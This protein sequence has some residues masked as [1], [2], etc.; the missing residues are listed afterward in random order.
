MFK[1]QKLKDK[2]TITMSSGIILL[3]AFWESELFLLS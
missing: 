3:T 2:K 1:S